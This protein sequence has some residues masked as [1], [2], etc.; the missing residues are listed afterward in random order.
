MTQPVAASP[1]V[2]F[3]TQMSE[4]V[5]A[6]LRETAKQEGIYSPFWMRPCA[7]ISKFTDRTRRVAMSF[8]PYRPA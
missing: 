4:D 5:L 7:N 6:L 3:A 2:K 1:K 8:P